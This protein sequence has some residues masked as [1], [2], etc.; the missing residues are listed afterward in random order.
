MSISMDGL[1]SYY[2]SDYVQESQSSSQMED[3]LNQDYTSSSDEELMEVCKEFESYLM[4]QL[5]KSMKSTVMEDDE[6][7]TLF[8]T[9]MLDYFE[10]MQ[11]Q[12]YA[13]MASEQGGLGIAQTLY[14][15]MKRD[16]NL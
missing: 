11:T 16:Y 2:T 12:E 6:D 14:E 7:D 15:A 5:Y 10:D 3:V 8:S 9:N 4:E 1:A 13:S